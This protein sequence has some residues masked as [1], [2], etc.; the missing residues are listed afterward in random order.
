M[1]S[2]D[3]GTGINQ[4]VLNL[5]KHLPKYGY[6][7]TEDS[8]EAALFLP[9]AGA[10]YGIDV[11]RVPMVAVV[12]G[13]MPTGEGHSRTESWHYVVNARVIDDLRRADEV[14][15]PSEWVADTIRRDMR[16]NPHVIGWGVDTDVWKPLENKGYVLWNKNRNE[17][18]CNPDIL[19]TL[20]KALPDVQFVTTFGNPADNVKVI[21]RVDNAVMQSL[22][23]HAGLYLATTRETF[24]VGTLENLSAGVPVVGYNW[25]GTA[26]LVESGINGYLCEPNDV[27]GLI[28][29]IQYCIKHRAILSQNAQLSATWWSWGATAEKMAKVFDRVLQNAANKPSYHLDESFYMV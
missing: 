11:K 14:I 8:N 23:G 16:F 10:G 17:G 6:R 22:V 2:R 13:L 21:G 3:S 25:A 24:G 15:V 12:H 29:G 5:A 26:L 7:L 19:D 4:V 18:V 27:E 28:E 9:H 20:A 1:A